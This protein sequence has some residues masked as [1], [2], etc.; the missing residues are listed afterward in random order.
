MMVPRHPGE[1]QVGVP[2]NRKTAVL[3]SQVK[4]KGGLS[5]KLLRIVV[6]TFELGSEARDYQHES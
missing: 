1:N 2:T 6:L 3:S 5:D 4:A